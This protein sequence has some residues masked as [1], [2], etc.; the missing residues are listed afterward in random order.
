MTWGII[1]GVLGSFVAGVIIGYLYGRRVV[2]GIEKDLQNWIN[3]AT[4][5]EAAL[6]GK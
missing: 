2:S 1:A 3:R 6:R 5:A 4:K